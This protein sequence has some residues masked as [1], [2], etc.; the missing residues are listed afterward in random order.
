MLHSRN[1][2]Q[3]WVSKNKRFKTRK[4]T[5]RPW[6]LDIVVYFSEK[7]TG[8]SFFRQVV[9]FEGKIDHQKTHKKPFPFSTGTLG[10]QLRFSPCVTGGRSQVRLL[11]RTKC[12][13]WVATMETTRS[14]QWSVTA[15]QHSSGPRSLRWARLDPTL[16]HAYSTAKST[17]SGDGTGSV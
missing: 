17:S 1:L 9:R 7:K 2:I 10:I 3:L 16:A 5:E 12:T 15:L 8:K 6:N 4:M 11:Q 14:D 13:S